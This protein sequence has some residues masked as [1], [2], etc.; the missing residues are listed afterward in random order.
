LTKHCNTT[1][2]LLLLPPPLLLLLLMQAT[3]VSNKCYLLLLV[4]WGLVGRAV[5]V[6]WGLAG[7]G[8][9]KEPPE[10]LLGGWALGLRHNVLAWWVNEALGHLQQ[11]QQDEAWQQQ[12]QLVSDS[13]S[14]SSQRAFE[15]AA[16]QWPR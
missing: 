7:V 5:D 16:G 11:E 8:V 2:G 1:A 3:A 4:F 6:L 10:D 9:S 12:Q 15:A 14:V 13:M